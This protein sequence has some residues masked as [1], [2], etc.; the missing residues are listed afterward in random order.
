MNL[1][2]T[3]GRSL[4]LP[5]LMLF[6]LGGAPAYGKSDPVQTKTTTRQ[7]APIRVSGVVTDEKNQPLPG[8]TIV[9]KATSKGTATDQNGRFEMEVEPG[10][11]L[12]FTFIG[13]T[14]QEV[15]ITN[16]TSLSIQLKENAT[17][18]NEVVAVGYQ[19]VR[20]SDLTGAISSVKAKEL[21]LTAPT[22][23][24]SLVGKVAGVQVAQVSGAPYVGTKIRVRGVGSI[25]ASSDPLYVIDGYPAGHDVFINPN[26]IE[27]I[28]ILKDAASAAIY[29]SR[30]SGG[31]V[32]ITTKRGKEGKGRLEYD[33]QFGVH[34]LGKKVDLLNAEQFAQ[35]M[36]DARNGTYR[37]LVVNAGKPWDDAMYS[38]DNATR[39]AKVGNAS[40]V[41]IP[42]Y[43]YDFPGQKMI[44]PGHDTDWQDELYRNARVHRHNLA[45]SGGSQQVRYALSG[46]LQKQQGIIV[47][48][49]Q[50]RINFRGNI[51]ADVNKK[52]KVGANLAFT[53][54]DSREVQEG[55]F[56]QGP[57]LGALVYMPIFKAYNEDG[58]LAKFEA[59]SQS[60]AYGFQTIEN[61]VALATETKINRQGLR[62]TYNGHAVY[63]LLPGLSLKANLGMQTY[64]EKYEFYQPT[65][66]S[67]GANAPGSPQAI[68]AAKATAQTLEQRDQLAEFTFNYKKQLGRH[69]IDALGGYTAQKTTNDVLSVSAQG[70]Q[71]DRITEV[72]GKGADPSH[73][74]MNPG[75]GKSAYTL[76]SYLARAVYQF[77]NRYILTASFRTDGSSRFG[78]L[79]RW[80]NFPSVSAGWN[81][82]NESFYANTFGMASTL[83]LRASWGLSGNNNIGNYNHEQVMSN[84]GGV[85]FGNN[86]IATAMWPGNIMD[87]ELGWESTS[88]YNVGVDLGLF[89]NRL[90]VLTN[91]YRSNSFNLLF[92]QSVSAVSGAASMLTNLRDSRIENKG[93]DLQLDG[94]VVSGRDFN[95]N[96][97]GNLAV[98]RNKVLDMGGASTIMSA[99]AERSYLTHITQT[100]QPVGMFYGFKV[101]GMV[102]E[103]DMEKIKADA[104]HFNPQ[105]QSYPQG[106]VL[107]GPPRSMASSNP[108]KP[109]D[110]YFEDVN[111]D[112][113]VNDADKRVI[114]SPH[115]KFTYGLSVTMNYKNFDF[116]SSFNGSQGNQ[117]LDGQ[118]YYIFNMEGSGNQYAKVA[119]RYRSE[120]EPGN[121]TVYRAAR[122]G[123]QSNS[124]RLSTFYLQDGSFFRCTNLTIGYTLPAG[125]KQVGVSNVRIFGSVDNAFTL[126]KYL[127]YNPEVDYN[128]GT[129]LTPGVDYGKYPLVR[130]FNLGGKLTF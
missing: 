7:Q 44:T 80:G 123:T 10:A 3:C 84:P 68:A 67:S 83:K 103:S 57:I 73:F 129:N 112:G 59:A 53:S 6:V 40:A 105:T 75:T 28:D 74:Y 33:Y 90:Q 42:T 14:P 87:Q 109:G 26:D 66:L 86:T 93:F 88:Q 130:A 37:D 54:A 52:L 34:Q 27:S 64:Q 29:G 110:L 127:G 21:N 108:L 11:R 15:V 72:T 13:F 19:T 1:L 24:Q 99:G 30:A 125:L 98:N 92:N 82:S 47:S 49:G 124:T 17:M 9:E 89:D 70:F 35:L 114:G 118:D 120:L 96:V 94:K 121:G 101:M 79:N 106:Y 81:V 41:S 78:R 65:S 62:A 126:T 16:Q 58:S 2:S 69:S 55:R 71:N 39:I 95:L 117:V 36:I 22:V 122:G 115:P 12:T 128:N 4:G 63:E 107:Q 32:L 45:F 51:D 31:V 8:V 119:G 102:R 46:G 20:R 111:G 18:L 5:V 104:E 50:D 48:T 23:G 91:F 77:D 100:G 116:S 25:N 60:S 38:D 85:V 56:H 76:L 61:P 113:I 97:G 43:L